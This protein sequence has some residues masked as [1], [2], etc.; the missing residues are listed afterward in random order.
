MIENVIGI[1]INDRIVKL[2][3][4]AEIVGISTEWVQYILTTHLDMKKLS[5]R[6]VP[7]LLTI[8]NMFQLCQL[9]R[10]VW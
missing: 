6:W 7:Q 2:R 8:D 10:N 1:I 4:I 5:A 3:E 9:Q